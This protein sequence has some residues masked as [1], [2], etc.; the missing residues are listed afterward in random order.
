M[1][2]TDNK[3]RDKLVKN[4]WD[5]YAKQLIDKFNRKKDEKKI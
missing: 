5:F 2:N 3:E 4:A 1:K